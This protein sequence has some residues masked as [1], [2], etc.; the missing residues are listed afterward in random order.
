MA[1]NFT[2]LRRYLLALVTLCLAGFSTLNAQSQE[3]YC[4]MIFV[5]PVTGIVTF[6]F[7]ESAGG[8]DGYN[9]SGIGTGT[10]FPSS[11]IYTGSG[12][13]MDPGAGA[14]T[15]FIF[16]PDQNFPGS[17]SGTLVID[18]TGTGFIVCDYV[19][20]VLPLTL[21]KF[22]GYTTERNTNILEWV[23]ASEANTAWIILERSLDA[24]SWD[25]VERLP[26]Q[27]WSSEMH[28]YSA[29]DANPYALTYYR[30]RIVDLDG[31]EYFS[32]V[33]ALERNTLS[34]VTVSPVPADE[35]VMIR[36]DAA[37]TGELSLS[38]IDVLGQEISKETIPINI[39]LNTKTIDIRSL[40]VGLYYVTVDNGVDTHTKRI[41]KQ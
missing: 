1:N 34:G 14:M 10:G 8:D 4:P 31:A 11:V 38:I 18:F 35:E 32:N 33:I 23:T 7:P 19:D 36:F 39:G 29:E 27:G 5:D 22:D 16:D 30:L 3:D 13:F 9:I 37:E 12:S 40:P 28:Q 20:G 15:T 2:N 26:A 17:L 41:I 24:S 25:L 21:V 6:T